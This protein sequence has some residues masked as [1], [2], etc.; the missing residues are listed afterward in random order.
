MK[1]SDRDRQLLMLWLQTT[2]EDRRTVN[3]VFIFH[4][5]LQSKRPDLLVNFRGDPYRGLKSVLARHIRDR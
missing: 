2:P 3:D 5:W 1:N 4:G